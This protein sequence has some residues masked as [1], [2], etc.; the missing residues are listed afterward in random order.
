MRTSI[1]IVAILAVCGVQISGQ[2]SP[3]QRGRGQNVVSAPDAASNEKL[4]ESIQTFALEVRKTNGDNNGRRIACEQVLS[5]I[6]SLAQNGFAP[7]QSALADLY[8]D[9]RY[10]G[11]EPLFMV[12]CPSLQNPTEG[13]I[14][15]KRVADE[16][17]SLAQWRLGEVYAEAEVGRLD[18]TQA[19]ALFD[20]VKMGHFRDCLGKLMSVEDVERAQA[21]AT[22]YRAILHS[23]LI[24][25][26]NLIPR[27]DYCS[28]EYG[29]L[30]KP[31]PPVGTDAALINLE[32]GKV[33]S[34]AHSALGDF[35]VTSLSYHLPNGTQY[36][37]GESVTSLNVKN[38]TMAPLVVLLRGKVSRSISV[39]AG[40]GGTVMLFPGI[41]EV[42][43]Q[44]GSTTSNTIRYYGEKE[45]KNL[46]Y[47]IRFSGGASPIAA[48]RPDAAISAS[49]E[50]DIREEINSIARSGQ[51][52]PLPDAQIGLAK[53]ASA[54]AATRIVRNDT[55]YPLHLF[56]SGPVDR[57]IDLAPGGSTSIGIP[58][59]SYRIAARVDSA[60]VR[61]FYG[62]QVMEVGVE[63]TSQFYIK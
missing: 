30:V 13:F 58:P 7:A 35:L 5:N 28:E 14:W 10:L 46:T 42:G 4:K 1:T 55:A 60:G 34:E 24:D 32:L 62:V 11:G 53:G 8:L 52:S 56:M 18:L 50:S 25:V 12:D 49:A 57:K 51:Y 3:S 43:V 17:N 15:L 6:R 61:P 48:A 20:A 39:G 9:A 40:N 29:Q 22:R 23:G 44:L 26:S 27:I 2:T 21:L 16:G 63:Y 33:I 37:Q 36:Y 31:R 41:Y 19:Y 54:T 38:E 59:G 47:D 45:L